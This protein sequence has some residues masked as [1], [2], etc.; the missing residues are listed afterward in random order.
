MKPFSNNNSDKFLVVEQRGLRV[1]L[2][3]LFISF[4][5]GLTFRAIFSPQRI[6]YEIEKAIETSN[7]KQFEAKIDK[8]NLSLHENGLPRLAIVIENLTL[9]SLDECYEGAQIQVDNL[10][11]PVSITS[12]IERS[13]KISKVEIAHLKAHFKKLPRSNCSTTISKTEND[14]SSDSMV[15]SSPNLNSNSNSNSE[16]DS[17][18]QK[19][20]EAPIVQTLSVEGSGLEA[21]ELLEGQF[22]VDEFP[23][24]YYQFKNVSVDLNPNPNLDLQFEGTLNLQPLSGNKIQGLHTQV[25]LELSKN[26]LNSQIVGNWREGHIN[27]NLNYDTSN[28]NLE[29]Q[30]ELEQVPLGQLFILG[31]SMGW[32]KESPSARQSW[33]SLNAYY[34]SNSNQKENIKVENF[35]IEGDFGEIIST[36]ISGDKS[37]S[38]K[39]TWNDLKV[40]MKTV[41]LSKLLSVF[42]YGH[43]SP[44]LASLGVLDGDIEMQGSQIKRLKGQISGLEFIFSNKGIRELQV[45]ESFGVDLIED[46]QN[47][48]FNLNNIKLKNSSMDGQVSGR[49]DPHSKI[50]ELNINIQ[51]LTFNPQ[52]VRLMT[53]SG[54]LN[55]IQ[56]KL[57]LI[58]KQDPRPKVIYNGSLR[59]EKGEIEKVYFEKLKWDVNTIDNLEKTNIQEPIHQFKLTLHELKWNENANSILLL[60]KITGTESKNFEFRNIN[61]VAN[62]KQNMFEW[63]DFQA[64]FAND[65]KTKLVSQGAW[66]EIGELAGLIQIK[67]D[68]KNLREVRISGSREQPVFN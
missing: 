45:V 12:I 38:E 19:T 36:P 49:W 7:L 16:G 3:G 65:L 33:V 64:T 54:F 66:T 8:A 5:L 43:P 39:W 26:I 35:K 32:W 34:N 55:P 37:I 60:N 24:F 58:F 63:T 53:S 13:L 25:N 51:N 17:S 59:I 46:D 48:K 29:V 22:Y 52:V 31:Q 9:K 21:I 50:A 15:K 67:Q 6:K 68:K 18:N 28:K 61:L 44:T 30:G 4:F 40:S 1:V 62:K 20:P 56:G 47:L 41:I 23:G 57:N 11:I 2:T 27:F 42:D 10:T 14:L